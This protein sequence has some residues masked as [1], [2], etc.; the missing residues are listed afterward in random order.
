MSSSS[1]ARRPTS[2]ASGA[3][4][5][6]STFMTGKVRRMHRCRHT[7]V[8]SSD[9]DGRDRAPGTDISFTQLDGHLHNVS[10]VGPVLLYRAPARAAVAGRQQ[11]NARAPRAPAPAV[12]STG[13]T[14]H[15]G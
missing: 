4:T 6:V 10:A 11:V 5:P 3:I 2:A 8:V 15:R 14:H 1:L 7:P 13:R 9:H 12:A